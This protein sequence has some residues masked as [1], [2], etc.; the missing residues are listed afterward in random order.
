MV[1]GRGDGKALLG[2]LG[3]L[4]GGDGWVQDAGQGLI[5]H[6]VGRVCMARQY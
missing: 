4:A 2:L 5:V 3:L 6:W 1:G